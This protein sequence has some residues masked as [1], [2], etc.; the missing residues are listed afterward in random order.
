[1]NIFAINLQKHLSE[2]IFEFIWSLIISFLGFFSV[3]GGDSQD[4]RRPRWWVRRERQLIMIHSIAK[5]LRNYFQILIR[6]LVPVYWNCLFYLN[7]DFMLD[8]SARVLYKIDKE[9]G[10]FQAALL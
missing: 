6:A 9:I 2:I 7:N 8:F 5:L 10:T 1:M 4:A 3:Q